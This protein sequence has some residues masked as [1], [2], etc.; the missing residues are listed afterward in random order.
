MAARHSLQ[1]IVADGRCR[2]EPFFEIARL[3]QVSFSVGVM[4]PDPGIT[5][6]LELHSDRKRVCFHLR[7]LSL[8]AMHLFSDAKEILHMMADLMGDHIGLSKVTH[9]S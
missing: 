8:K 7:H 4:T 5:I 2:A 1:S 6:G 9:R 3:D